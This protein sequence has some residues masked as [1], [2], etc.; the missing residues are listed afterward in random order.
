MGSLEKTVS[1]ATILPKAAGTWRFVRRYPVLP[2]LIVALIL[3]CAVFAPWL[4]P[5]D[6]IRGNLRERNVPPMWYSEGSSAH[7]IGTDQLGRD[8]LS[9]VI[10]GARI[11]ATIAAVV[12]VVSS[13][14][15]TTAGMV[16]GYLGGHW[17]NLI[18]RFV[19]FSLAI[20]FVLIALAVVSV[21]GQSFT[22]IIA[23]LLLFSWAAFARQVRAEALQLK[24]T[25]YVALAKVAGASG[26]RIMLRHILPGVTNTAIVVAS[27][28]VGMLILMEA[29]LSFLGAGVPAPTPTWGGMVSDG[30]DF[31]ALAWWISFFP[32]MAIFLTVAA[33]NFLGDWMR[34]YFDPRLRQLVSL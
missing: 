30:R 19:D 14:I 26:G 18:M 22:M 33:F 27:L 13:V 15:G 2:G 34:D 20:P 32:G 9:R 10:F 5:H 16:S 24:T 8:V 7:I 23:L 12:L 6:P 17:D 1:R 29:L 4:A 25:D 21:M 3:V 28:R 31:I 11:S